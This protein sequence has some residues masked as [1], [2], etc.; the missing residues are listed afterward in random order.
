MKKLT[1]LITLVFLSISTF[2]Q[3]RVVAECTVVYN[4]TLDEKNVDAEMAAAL[5]ATTKTVYIKGVN[6]RTD[7]ISPSFS[8]SVIY[9]KTNASATILRGIGTNKFMTKLDRAKWISEHTRYSN[10]KLMKSDEVK[11][12]LGYECKKLVLEL[13]DGTSLTVFYAANITPSVKEFE[14]QFKDVPGFVL[15]YEATEGEDKKIKYTAAQINFNP[16]AAS[17]FDI[18]TS[19]YRILN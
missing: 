5:K 1:I 10:M 9:N 3:Q 15:E 19:G 11:V 2:A 16:V 14:Y 8:Q 12:I 6:S 13:T 18:P 4:I 7:L 17:R